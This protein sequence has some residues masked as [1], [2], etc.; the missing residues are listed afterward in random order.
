MQFLSLHPDETGKKILASFAP[1]EGAEITP[2][3][4][5]ALK[6]A[7]AIAGYGN[8]KLDEIAIG[9]AVAK[10]N[11]GSAFDIEVAKAVDGQLK[12]SISMDQLSAYLSCDPPQGGDPVTAE[13][14]VAEARRKGIKIDMDM[15]A[16]ERSLPACSEVLIASGKMPV[17]G[18]D[19]RVEILIPTIGIRSPH[20]DKDGLADFRELGDV[21]TVRAGQPLVR[22][23]P[24][25]QGVPGM[26]LTG[27]TLPAKQGKDITFGGKLEG[28]TPDPNDP[29]VLVA[30]IDGF[31]VQKR[32]EVHVEPV[33]TVQDV[34]LHTGNISFDGTVHVT[35]DVHTGMTVKSTGDI[36]V[37]GTVEGANLEA[38]G[39]I[40]VKGGILALSED[41]E[42]HHSRIHCGGSCT[43]HFAQ[44]AH[45]DAGNGIFI[46]DYAMQCELKAGHQILV[47]DEHSK[48]GDIIGGTTHGAML[49]KA[50]ALGSASYVH[51]VVVAGASR[52][53]HEKLKAATESREAAEH[54]LADLLKLIEF[55]K[56]HPGR[57]PPASLHAVEETRVATEQQIAEIREEEQE[58]QSEIDLTAGAQ[59]IVEKKVYP[60]TDVRFG[61]LH[62]HIDIERERGIFQLKDGELVFE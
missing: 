22:H 48:R 62:Q 45:I 34:D 18:E 54:K 9:N 1:E 37:D 13:A 16:I 32:N 58:L 2:V 26:T 43:T 6:A 39:D 42:K 59:V 36:H 29:N 31:P 28:V 51:T 50:H 20:I 23:I 53:L 3:D 14:V 61:L 11:A 40:T 7:L 55:D 4:A 27:K 5:E 60:G 56:Q 8:H 38:A 10:Y 15:A 57:L 35:G 47:G 25:T 12:V 52:E 46:H 30:A 41:T 21:P 24:P 19:G 17:H 33:Y 44:N 49:V